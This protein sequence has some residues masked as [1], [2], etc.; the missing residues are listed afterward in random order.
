MERNIKF[1]LWHIESGIMMNVDTIGFFN[2]GIRISD[3]A[4]YDGWAKVEYGFGGHIRKTSEL[5]QYTGLKDNNGVD[6]YEGDIIGKESC[7]NHYV[8]FESGMFV[9]I[10]TNKI[11]AINIRPWKLKRMIDSGYAKI[12]NIY[13]NKNLLEEK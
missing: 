12:G 5:M 8:S 2:G 11:Q 6:L 7:Q 9:G 4:S 1:R 10:S 3:G 13:E